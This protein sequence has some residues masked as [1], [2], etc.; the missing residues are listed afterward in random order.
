MYQNTTIMRRVIALF[1]FMVIALTAYAQGGPEYL[2]FKGVPIKGSMTEFCQKL[3]ATGLTYT[4]GK[5]NFALFEGDFTGR[6]ATIGVAATD[7]GESIFAVVVFF[8]PSGEWNTLVSTYDY[9]K[10]LYTRKYGEPSVLKEHNPARLDSNIA[11]MAE[12]T[13]GTVV[14]ACLWEV[15]GGEIEISI[16]SSSEYYEG[17]VMICYR[18]AQNGEAKI[19]DDLE[20]I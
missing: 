4:G 16:E 8:N 6:K 7:D 10:D 2:T 12:V 9:Y 14:W 15:P 18:D 3:K 11:L 19:Q 17:M 1:A 13:N 20:E 5:S